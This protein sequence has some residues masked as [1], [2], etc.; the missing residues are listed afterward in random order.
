MV[1]F[2]ENDSVS[3]ETQAPTHFSSLE[4]S[5][6]YIAGESNGLRLFSAFHP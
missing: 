5:L 4:M 1:G 2:D 3:A 6:E